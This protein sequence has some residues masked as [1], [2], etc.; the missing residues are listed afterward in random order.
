MPAI[1]SPCEKI[2]Q[3]DPPSGLCRGCGRRLD[4]IAGWSTYTDAER[5][6][7][8]MDLPRRLEAVQARHRR[9][10]PT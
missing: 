3:V 1:V 8:M 5:A 10:A 4:E 2:C 7:I 9:A 6:Q